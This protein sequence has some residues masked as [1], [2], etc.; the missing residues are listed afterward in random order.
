MQELTTNKNISIFDSS[1]NIY[2]ERLIL[3]NLTTAFDKVHEKLSDTNSKVTKK[4]C[5]KCLTEG[6]CIRGLTNPAAV[7]ILNI[8]IIKQESVNYYKYIHPTTRPKKSLDLNDL[9]N[10]ITLTDYHSRLY[11]NEKK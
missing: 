11:Q 9:S 1:H 10:A 7:N 2:T 4:H 6:R 5:S 3:Y 8:T